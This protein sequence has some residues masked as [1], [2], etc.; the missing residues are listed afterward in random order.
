MN[1]YMPFN[2]YVPASSTG[3][4]SKIFKGGLNWSTI[5]T[6][7]QKTL[8]IINQAIPVIKQAGP[9][10]N[11]AKTMFRIMNEFKKV[12]TPIKKNKV[13]N[14]ISTDKKVVKTQSY[15]NNNP[16]FFV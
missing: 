6:N 1:Y 14:D 16:V 8:N 7:T 9:V 15:N 2:N 11:N 5:L 12:D 13:N 4:L 10:M 3:L